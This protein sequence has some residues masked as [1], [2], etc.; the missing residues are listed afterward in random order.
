M[1]YEIFAKNIG[2]FGD[3]VRP[4][5]INMNGDGIS[6]ISIDTRIVEKI[7]VPHVK[8]LEEAEEEY[9]KRFR[10]NIIDLY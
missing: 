8:S 2:A 4:V 10:S 5:Y 9:D 1:A 3:R 7:D 6:V